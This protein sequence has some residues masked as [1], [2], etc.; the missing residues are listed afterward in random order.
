MSLA[1][2]DFDD[3]GDTDVFV[4]NDAS[5]NFLL[6]NEGEGRFSEA[7]LLSGVAMGE[8]GEQTS[9]MAAVVGDV[10]GDGQIDLAVS[11]TAFGALYLRTR[12]G[13]FA[14][15]VMPSGLGPLMGQ[16]VSWGQ[17]LLDFDNDGDLDMFVANADLHHLVGWEDLLLRNTGAGHF[18]DASMD[19]GAYF[20]TRQVGRSS[21]TGDYDNDG[22]IDLFVTTIQ[23]RPFLLRN[24]LSRDPSWI[25]LDL[26]G[27][28][29][30]DPF[31]ARVVVHV[32]AR[33]FVSESRCPSAY[34]GQSDPRIHFGLGEG[35]ERVDRISIVWPDGTSRTLTD[36]PARQI[37]RIE[38]REE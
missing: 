14:D 34:L 29:A 18:E 20:A 24:D 25:T 35:V 38:E 27:R 4:A 12:P 26:I 13:L 6:L 28:R 1:V 37:L 7:G 23:G 9:A 31:G 3:D 8:N 16:Y 19:G 36:V 21:I 22:D 30:R 11:D 15:E 33:T 17:N 2:S 5:G 10:D 32:G